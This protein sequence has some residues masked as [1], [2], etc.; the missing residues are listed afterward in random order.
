MCRVLPGDAAWPDAAAWLRFNSSIGG[1]LI[2]T[3]PEAAPCHD[4]HFD[5]AA[6]QTLKAEWDLPLGHSQYPSSIDQ[7]WFQNG[8]CDPFHLRNVSCTLGN[9]VSYSV[10]VTSAAQVSTT[11]RFAR[12]KNLRIAIKNTGHDF[13]GKNTAKGGLGIWTHNLNS[14]DILWNYTS[15]EYA[16]P[17]IKIGAGT[18]AYAA[19]EAAH[20]VGYRV[21]GGTCPTVGLAGGYTQGGGHSA[22]SSIY[23]MAADSVLEWEVVTPNGEHIT[24]S[25]ESYPDLY[26]A[27]SGG[28]GGTFGVVISLTTKLYKD[29]PTVGAQIFFNSTSAPGSTFWEAAE[30]FHGGLEPIVDSG[31]VALFAVTNGTFLAYVTAPSHTEAQIASQLKFITGFLDSKNATYTLKITSDPSYFD[32]FVRFYGPLPGGIWETSHLISS[33]LIPRSVVRNQNSAITNL[34]RDIVKDGDWIVSGIVLNASHKVAGNKP[35]RNAVNPAWRQALVHT[36]VYSVWDWEAPISVMQA[37][38]DHLTNYIS[39]S[40]EALTPSSGTYLNEA[41]F[42]QKNWQDVFYGNNYARLLAVKHKYDP[43]GL[44]YAPTAVGADAWVLAG[45]GRLCRA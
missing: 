17:A 11:L 18:Q 36:I 6:C 40:L 32:H 24:A 41:N 28:G 45:D 5:E 14:I 30:K 22:L 13:L 1:S 38:E 29:T 10:N 3:I 8:T 21:L 2:A 20:A 7:P 43:E 26:W 33:R 34:Y 12:S 23:G 39:P 4:P 25:P 27:I 16:G 44:L 31:A 19:Y 35:G 42:G 37:R 15:K 9:L